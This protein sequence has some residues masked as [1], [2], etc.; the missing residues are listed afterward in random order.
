MKK[1]GASQMAKNQDGSASLECNVYF[2]LE[3]RNFINFMNTA[4]SSVM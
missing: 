1:V 4:F 3:N 2:E